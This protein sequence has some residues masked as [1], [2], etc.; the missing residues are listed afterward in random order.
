MTHPKHNSGFSLVELSIVLVILGLLTGGILGGQALIKAAELR[1][2]TTEFNTWLT[3]VNTFKGKYFQLPGDMNNATQFWGRADNGSFSGQC[4]DPD[5]DEG[6]GTQTCNGN[7][8]G[9]VDEEY[10]EL[11]FWQHL[12]NAGLINGE[13]TGVPGSGGLGHAVIGEN[14][15]RAKYNNGGWGT[16]NEGDSAGDSDEFAYNYGHIFF[17]GAQASSGDANEDLFT[18]EDLWNIDTKMDDGKPG[19]GKVMVFDWGDCTDA[20]SQTDNDADYALDVSEID[21]V[22]YFPQA[23]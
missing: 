1:S 2:V 23:Y 12:A 17:M 11:R 4:A 19:R 10:E 9:M 18:P 14:T 7:G 22:A 20:S 13:F 6:S 5:D 15:P 8:D 21:C 16:D 3:A